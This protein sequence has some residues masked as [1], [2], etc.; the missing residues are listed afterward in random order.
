[1]L[2]ANGVAV[3]EPRQNS[4]R[5]W[6]LVVDLGDGGQRASVLMPY[7]RKVEAG[8][9]VRIEYE[10]SGESPRGRWIRARRIIP[11]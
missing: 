1:M 10:E 8:Q 6:W 3:T 5:K 9:P 2:I 11:N 7:H 4:I